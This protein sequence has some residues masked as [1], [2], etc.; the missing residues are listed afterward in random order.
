M[1]SF[2]IRVAQ[3][4]GHD[5]WPQDFVDLE[6][7]KMKLERVSK[8]QKPLFQKGI[9]ILQS[10]VNTAKMAVAQY[11]STELELKTGRS[12]HSLEIRPE[13]IYGIG[14]TCCDDRRNGCA[15]LGSCTA[16]S[17]KSGLVAVL[18]SPHA[19]MGQT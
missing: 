4:L 18:K 19:G 9:K 17:P 12:H 8:D 1:N 11:E 5:I 3:T 7:L 16:T 10:K 15:Y 14:G 13:G 6:K 2:E